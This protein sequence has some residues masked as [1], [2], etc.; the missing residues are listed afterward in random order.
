MKNEDITAVLEAKQNNEKLIHK[1]NPI[2]SELSFSLTGL[3]NLEKNIIFKPAAAVQE[4]ILASSTVD[5]KKCHS[6]LQ[7]NKGSAG[8]Y[9]RI[10]F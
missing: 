7:A 9:E 3:L 5:V 6:H 10:S 1:V 4:V 2:V 8:I